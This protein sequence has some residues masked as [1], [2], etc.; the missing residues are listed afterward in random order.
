MDN[1]I[2]NKQTPGIVV[3]YKVSRQE[4][5]QTALSIRHEVFVIEQHVPFNE[6]AD[7]FDEQSNHY[8]AFYNN[9]PV[10]TARWRITSDG[11]KLERFS[12]LKTYRKLGIAGCLVKQLLHDCIQYRIN[13]ND[14]KSIYL[15]AQTEVIGLYENFGFKKA[16]DQFIESGIRHCR[17]EFVE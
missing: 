11:I 6:E 4:D 7:E 3:I 9:I 1:S 10:G 14:K 16:G 12:V 5:I 8:L 15:N 13:H 2:L 17:M